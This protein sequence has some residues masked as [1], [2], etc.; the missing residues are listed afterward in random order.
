MMKLIEKHLRWFAII[1]RRMRVSLETQNINKPNWTAFFHYLSLEISD[2]DNSFFELYLNLK[3]SSNFHSR[4]CVNYVQ[5]A[6]GHF[7]RSL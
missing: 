6:L 4:T 2:F 3:R 7:S 5:G 1:S